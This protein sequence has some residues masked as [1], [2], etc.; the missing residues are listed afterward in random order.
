MPRPKKLA[1]NDREWKALLRSDDKNLVRTMNDWEKLHASDDNP[2]NGINTKIVSRFTKTLKFKNGGLAH[3]DFSML[4]DVVP[5]SKFRTIW[6]HF[7]M[8]LELFADHEG[9]YCAGQGDCSS[10]NNHICTS[11][12]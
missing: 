2:L 7:G 4:V 6:E 12:C 3:A 11:N 1:R 8:S 10:M 9:Y 5:F